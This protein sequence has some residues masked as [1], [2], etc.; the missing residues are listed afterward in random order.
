MLTKSLTVKYLFPLLLVLSFLACEKKTA[1]NSTPKITQTDMKPYTIFVG[2]YTK[3]EGHVDGKGKGIHQIKFTSNGKTVEIDTVV[4]SPE[5]AINPSYLTIAPNKKFLY[6][7]NELNPN[8]GDAGTIS[9]YRIDPITKQLQLI[10]QQ[11]T[12]AYAPCHV[13]VDATN[14]L[15]LVS[16]YVGGVVMVYPLLENGALGEA[17]QVIQLE[18]K[19]VTNR[20]EASHP[21]STI[22]SP[23]NEHVYIADLGTDIISGYRIDFEKNQ[24][25]PTAQKELK[26]QAGAG[27]RHLDFHPNGKTAYVVNELDATV[28]VFDYDSET[29]QLTEKQSLSTVPSKYTGETWCADIHV[30]PAGNFLYVSN[31]GHNSIGI[32][33]IEAETGM[34]NFVGTESTLGDH[35]R[36]FTIDPTGNFLW[37]ANQNTNDI[38]V[39]EINKKTGA[40]KNVGKVDTPT[41]V[42]LKFL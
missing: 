33:S 24:L 3:K 28:N 11:K 18:G 39:F 14:R 17:S 5:P 25:I 6:A 30:H 37:V 15:A 35:P 23:D 22:I 40:L 1:P 9:A 21:H 2:T 26:L 7:A 41:P 16:N 10:N 31:R 36:N 27:P 12:N 32:F 20:Q 19:G 42:C 34:L 4:I 8:D 29:G 13:S 38:F